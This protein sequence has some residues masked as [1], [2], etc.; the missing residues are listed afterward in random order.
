MWGGACE[1]GGG[2]ELETRTGEGEATT[3]KEGTRV[4]TG[5]KRDEEGRKLKRRVEGWRRQQ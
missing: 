2:E 1:N 5:K 4:T 3:G